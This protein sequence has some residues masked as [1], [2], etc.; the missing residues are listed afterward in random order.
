MLTAIRQC[1]RQPATMQIGQNGQQKPD[2]TSIVKTLQ[3]VLK[4]M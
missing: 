2:L 1:Q 3:H 4:P